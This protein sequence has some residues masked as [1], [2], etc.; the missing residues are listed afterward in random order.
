M[1]CPGWMLRLRGEGLHGA[2][3]QGLFKLH[4]PACLLNGH[5]PVCTDWGIGELV[6]FGH[7]VC[8]E[9]IGI[10]QGIYLRAG[11][12]FVLV[13]DADEE[14]AVLGEG[15]EGHA[16]HLNVRHA[17]LVGHLHRLAAGGL[18]L[19]KRGLQ[20]A[21]NAV[22]G[23]RKIHHDSFCHI[24]HGVLVQHGAA[25]EAGDG[26]SGGPGRLR[27]YGRRSAHGQSQHGGQRAKQ[28]FQAV[29]PFFCAPVHRAAPYA[30]VQSIIFYSIP[31]SESACTTFRRVLA[32]EVLFAAQS[33]FP[34]CKAPFRRARC[35]SAAQSAPAAA[36]APSAGRR[37]EKQPHSWRH[38]F[39]IRPCK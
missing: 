12:G 14:H 34:P 39:F 29:S 26:I 16:V 36:K 24:Q 15:L 23:R 3:R 8:P 4:A 21:V 22:A 30:P 9:V 37:A 7:A 13:P 5:L 20:G 17:R 6:V 1:S 19:H 33:A 38:R 2:F 28:A 18:F 32:G 35:L 11:D 31:H 10:A 27:P 25:L